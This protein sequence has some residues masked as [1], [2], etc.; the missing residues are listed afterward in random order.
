MSLKELLLTVMVWPLL[1]RCTGSEAGKD[2][3]RQLV[4]PGL[5]GRCLCVCAASAVG[6]GATHQVARSPSARRST[7]A[8]NL[9]RSG[10]QKSGS[11]TT[12][13]KEDQPADVTG[14]KFDVVSNS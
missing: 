12:L 1:R 6:V 11:Q 10:V 8:S 5:R 14:S 9:S 3:E 7:S 13:D 2:I 4:S